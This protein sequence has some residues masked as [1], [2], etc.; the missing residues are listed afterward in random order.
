MPVISIKNAAIKGY[1]VYQ[2]RAP[3]G[4]HLVV[5]K[6]YGNP[7]DQY[8]LMIYVPELVDIE[9]SMHNIV[10]DDKRDLVLQQVAGLPMGHVPYILSEGIYKCIDMKLASK[11]TC[12]VTGGPRQSFPPWPAVDEKGGGALIPADY[13]I[14]VSDEHLSTAVKLVNDAIQKMAEKSVLEV[15]VV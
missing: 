5:K 10:T 3:E 11:V 14:T 9:A 6:E 7:H 2:V 4:L 13:F 15:V 8:A 12:C 1:H